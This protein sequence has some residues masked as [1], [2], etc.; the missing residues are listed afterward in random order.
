M[1]ASFWKLHWR[2]MAQCHPKLCFSP[3]HLGTNETFL[4]AQNKNGSSR[5]P[6]QF[7][8]VYI[9]VCESIWQGIWEH[10]SNKVEV[11]FRETQNEKDRR[12]ETTYKEKTKWY[13]KSEKVLDY[14][15]EVVVG[16]PYGNFCDRST[17]HV[18]EFKALKTPL[19]TLQGD[20]RRLLDHKECI[21]R[22]FSLSFPVKGCWLKVCYYSYDLVDKT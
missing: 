18:S 20:L 3:K 13:K 2:D 16:D 1:H 19:V 9:S 8:V 21:Y 17:G 5:A 6:R 15:T 7:D 11:W 14:S 22:T 4:T 12:G 10:V